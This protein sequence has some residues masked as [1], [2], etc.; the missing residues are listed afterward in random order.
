MLFCLTSS[1]VFILTFLYFNHSI[2]EALS[3]VPICYIPHA[4]NMI[5]N[6]QKPPY[7]PVRL[8]SHQTYM[9]TRPFGLLPAIINT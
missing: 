2:D 4:K 5:D 9:Q 6:H 7:N 8:N 3:E 1:T